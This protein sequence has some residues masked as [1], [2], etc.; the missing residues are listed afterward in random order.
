MKE[1]SVYRELVPRENM[2]L[3]LSGNTN[4]VGQVEA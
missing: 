2:P 3:Y 1:D 4:V